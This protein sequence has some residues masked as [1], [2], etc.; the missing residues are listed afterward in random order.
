MVPCWTLLLSE[1][2]VSTS[3]LEVI[4]SS[5]QKNDTSKAKITN[6]LGS[7]KEKEKER[8]DSLRGETKREVATPPG[9]G[10]PFKS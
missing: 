5:L 6:V 9:F 4:K 8:W 3:C 7:T 1:D 2:E 10:E